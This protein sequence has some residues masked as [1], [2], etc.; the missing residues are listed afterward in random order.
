[1]NITKFCTFPWLPGLALSILFISQTRCP[2][3]SVHEVPSSRPSGLTTYTKP[4]P[5]LP[6]TIW[7]Q[8]SS[9]GKTCVYFPSHQHQRHQCSWNNKPD[10]RYLRSLTRKEKAAA[11]QSGSL[12]EILQ[13]PG[14]SL[15]CIYE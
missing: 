8:F 5:P 6:P 2:E 10:S 1:M 11:E 13:P 12:I 7:A 3:H 4:Y 15:I 14:T 9:K